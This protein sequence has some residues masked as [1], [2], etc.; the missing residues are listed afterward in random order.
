MNEFMF[1]GLAIGIYLLEEYV[2]ANTRYFWV[3]GILPLLGTLGI[4]YILVKSS[5]LSWNDY[6]MAAIGVFVLLGVWGDGHNRYL[7]RM[8]KQRNQMLAQDLNEHHNK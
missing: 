2:F 8:K 3:G 4:I 5:G 7:R 1:F 6:L